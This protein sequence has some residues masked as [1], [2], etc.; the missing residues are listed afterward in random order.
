LQRLVLVLSGEVTAAELERAISAGDVAA[1]VLGR[2]L[3]ARDDLADIAQARGVATLA[4]TPLDEDGAPAWPLADRFDGAHLEG[5]VEACRRAVERR[6]EG[7]TVGVAAGDRHAA[8]VLGEAGADYVWFG[9]TGRLDEDA[10]INACW[11]QKLFEVPCVVAGPCDDEA[12]TRL[13]ASNAEFVAVDVFS[14]VSDPAGRVAEIAGAL[15]RRA[16]PS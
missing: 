15:E 5:A 12:I 6:P 2:D 14:G 11:W 4:R 16:D 1:A 8:M 13:I 7:V 10:V 3:A 9:E